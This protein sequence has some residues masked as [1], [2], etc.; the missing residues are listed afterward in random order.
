MSNP[1]LD[2]NDAADL[3]QRGWLSAPHN[4]T[5]FIR[6][7]LMNSPRPLKLINHN[8]NMGEL[9]DIPTELE[10]LE[11]LKFIG[12]NDPTAE[13]IL[14]SWLSLPADDRGSFIDF[15]TDYIRNEYKNVVDTRLGNTAKWHRVMNACGINI[16]TQMEIRQ[17]AL[18][19][20][21]LNYSVKEWVLGTM[22]SRF[23]RLELAQE[24]SKARAQQRNGLIYIRSGSLARIGGTDDAN[25]EG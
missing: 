9:V 24:N 19:V 10:S 1:I 17:T 6:R 5:Q 15:A 4:G 13:C 21:R 8:A 23:S 7:N 22:K 16:D 2:P 3:M 18:E 20:W 25:V 14:G 11:T 12:Y